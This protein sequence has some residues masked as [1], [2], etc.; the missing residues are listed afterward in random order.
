[1]KQNLAIAEPLEREWRRL[2][3]R[4]R[5]S[6]LPG[7]LCWWRDALASWIPPRWRRLLSVDR[8]PL[9]LAVDRDRLELRVANQPASAVTVALADA[10]M[11]VG[12]LEQEVARRPRKLLIDAGKALRCRL[13]LPDAAADRLREVAGFEIDRQTPFQ[14][15]Q[16]VY[17]ARILSRDANGQ[18]SAELVVLPGAHLEAALAPLGGLAETLAAVDLAGPDG[19]PLGINLLPPERRFHQVDPARRINAILAATA[20]LALW[21]ALWQALDN[22]RD[23]VEAFVSAIEVQ[24]AEARQVSAQR[25]RLD[26]AAEGAGFLVRQRAARPPVID[27]L[28]D[29]S[30]RLPDETAL[31]RL[32]L[33]GNRLVIIGYSSRAP[34]TVARLQDSPYLRSPALSGAVQPDR[35]SGRDRF[36]LT[37]DVAT[38]E[39]A[40]PGAAG[41]DATSAKPTGSSTGGAH[42]SR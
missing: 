20:L 38:P 29:L 9:W 8:A 30:R 17:D 15:D 27:L 18:L 2:K 32:N 11:L 40:G 5:H 33:N 31:E 10:P 24:R 41:A 35:I 6:P 13:S 22:R 42:G 4:V 16:V 14:A 19:A 39:A 25:Q 26:D 34:G 37:A 28:E 1:M 21:F 12:R 7:F 3:L 36:T 23:A